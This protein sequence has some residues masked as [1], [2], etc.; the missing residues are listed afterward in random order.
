VRLEFFVKVGQS[1]RHKDVDAAEQVTLGNAVVEMELV[2]Q[3]ALIA[4]PPP[5]HRAASTADSDQRTESPF[6]WPLNAFI[7]S[8]DSSLTWRNV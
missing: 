3:P 4:S 6:G 2:E 5:H 7:D 8:I 1:R